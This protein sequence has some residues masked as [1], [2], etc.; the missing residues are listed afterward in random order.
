MTSKFQLLP[1]DIEER[2][3]SLP[4]HLTGIDGLAA[5]WLFGSFARGEATPVSDVDLA[6]LPDETLQ[7]EEL[8][9]FETR[10]YSAISGALRTDDF[11]FANLR[12][13]PARSLW[14]V[15]T[16]GRPLMCRDE[17]ACAALKENAFQ[18]Y[19]DSRPYLQERWHA[20][21]DWLEGKSMAVEKGRV[22]ALFEGIREELSLLTEMTA[23]SR[24][25]YLDDKRMQRL[26]E[27]CL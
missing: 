19:P 13:A 3:K 10:L 14:H 27:R 22:Y 17:D 18:V 9:R 16:E 15:M 26:A 2:L 8:D 23:L 21:D 12:R 6:Y 20:V 24:D 5:A 1:R 11:T 7:G 25:A 4:E